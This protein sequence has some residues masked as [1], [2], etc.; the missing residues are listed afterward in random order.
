V[1]SPGKPRTTKKIVLFGSRSIPSH[2]LRITVANRD[3]FLLGLDKI[4]RLV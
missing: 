2:S 3:G 1:V 4:R